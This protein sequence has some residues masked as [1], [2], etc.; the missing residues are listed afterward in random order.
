MT[1]ET[2]SGVDRVLTRALLLW[3]AITAVFVVGNAVFYAAAGWEVFDTLVQRGPVSGLKVTWGS[4]AAIWLS[5]GLVLALLRHPGLRRRDGLLLIAS[6]LALVLYANVLRERPVYPDAGDYIRAAFDLHEGRPFHPRYIYPPLLAA[7]GEPLVPF[8]QGTLKLAIWLANLASVPVLLWLLSLTLQRYGFDRRAATLVA[9]GFVTLNVP[10]LRTLV[11]GQVN[12]H[13]V[14]LTLIALLA[15]PRSA[16]A[17]GLALALA[18]HLKMSPL[19]LAL[20][21]V[22][23]RSWRWTGAFVGGL[24]G[25]AGLIYAVH[26]ATPFEAFLA[27]TG[28]L[29]GWERIAFREHSVESLLRHA[30]GLTGGLPGVAASPTVILAV[31][32]LTLAVALWVAAIAMVRRPFVAD[33]G[34]GRLVLNG[35]PA[36][37]LLMALA[38]PLLWVHHGVFLAL[39]FLVVTTRLRD[40]WEWALFCLAYGVTYLLP[41]FDFFPWSFARLGALFVLL[42][43]L[44]RVSRRTGDGIVLP[45]LRGFVTPAS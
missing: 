40:A 16:L 25:V 32:G 14:N 27:N 34:P 31:K 10:I 41:T 20:P 28:G 24:A 36:L 43:L 45:W 21:F 18:V 42:G 2:R 13:V 30:A 23:E 4:V 11:Y 33:S 35:W 37:A 29:M 39:P 7:L 9:L 15:Y 5:S 8:G 22:L 1:G 19:V 3:V 38:S 26:G 12:L 17:S 6:F 44:F